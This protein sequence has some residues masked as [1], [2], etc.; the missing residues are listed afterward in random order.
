MTAIILIDPPFKDQ[1]K[2]KEEFV[3]TMQF[4]FK[5]NKILSISFL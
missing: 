3:T 4:N 1:V 5:E 2:D